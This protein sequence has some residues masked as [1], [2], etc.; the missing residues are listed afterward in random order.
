[1]RARAMSKK[2]CGGKNQN[3]RFRSRV[4]TFRGESQGMSYANK[5]ETRER[6]QLIPGESTNLRHSP[7]EDTPELARRDS[8]SAQ[9]AA[10]RAQLI[11][12]R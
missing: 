6:E 5:G 4:Q 12:P 8:R 2:Q 11:D 3:C 10:F 7:S 9:E 1:M